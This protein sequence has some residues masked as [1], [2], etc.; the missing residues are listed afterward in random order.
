MPRNPVKEMR[1]PAS[2]SEVTRGSQAGVAYLGAGAYLRDE[3]SLAA[4][5]PLAGQ[6]LLSGSGL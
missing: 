3:V 5:S 2:L 1:F 4:R 6:R